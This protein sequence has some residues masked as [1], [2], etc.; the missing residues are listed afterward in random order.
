M[1]CATCVSHENSITPPHDFRD[2]VN[3]DFL[4]LDFEKRV[5]ARDRRSEDHLHETYEALGC[6][7]SLA[8]AELH[9]TYALLLVWGS[10]FTFVC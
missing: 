5:P 7:V 10:G 2:D 1:T 9:L 8:I 3:G 6:L 4:G